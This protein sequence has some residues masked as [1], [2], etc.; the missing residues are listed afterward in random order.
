MYPAPDAAFASAQVLRIRRLKP[1]QAANR[2]IKCEPQRLRTNPLDALVLR[3]RPII[4][5][6][7][8]LRKNPLARLGGNRLLLAT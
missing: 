3:V 7:Q 1:S 4:R 6:G 2:P 8:R 5:E